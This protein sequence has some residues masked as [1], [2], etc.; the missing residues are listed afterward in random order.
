LKEYELK[1]HLGN[2]LAT[3]SDK[4]L[5]YSSNDSTVDYYNPD[6]VSAQD[7]YPFGMLQPGR[8]YLSSTGSDYRYGF[9]GKENDNEVKG[10]GNQQDYGMRVYDPRLGKFLSVDPLTK[11]YP[12]YTPYQFAGNT[13]IQ[14]IDL[15]GLEEWKVNNGG[16]V[17]GPYANQEAAQEAANRDPSII[18]YNYKNLPEHVVTPISINTLLK[19]YPRKLSLAVSGA[20]STALSMYSGRYNTYASVSSEEMDICQKS[21]NKRI[22]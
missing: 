7:Y 6:I 19:K 12:W 16:T 21:K 14:A 22:F 17:I 15:D 9:N 13:P 10:E 2:V 5:G 20:Y 11:D 8:S 3:V 1:N 4:K 18:K